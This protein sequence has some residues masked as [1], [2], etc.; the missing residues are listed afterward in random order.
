MPWD[1]VLKKDRQAPAFVSVCHRGV[2]GAVPCRVNKGLARRL[3]VFLCGIARWTVPCR[4]ALTSGQ[5]A[6]TQAQ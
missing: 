6:I 2:A 5:R 3:P 1:A 4:A